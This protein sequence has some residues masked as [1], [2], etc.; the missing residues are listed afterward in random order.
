[1]DAGDFFRFLFRFID[2]SHNMERNVRFLR[3]QMAPHREKIIPFSLQEFSLLSHHLSQI[4]GGIQKRNGITG[5]IDTIYYEHLYIWA[6]KQWR[7]RDII[8]VV[9]ST[10]DKFVY[11]VQKDIFRVFM[12]GTEAGFIDSRG[13]FY[14]KSRQVIAYWNQISSA[15]T[16]QIDILG[17]KA[18]FVYNY[19]SED[20]TTPRLLQIFTELTEDEYTILMCLI[21]GKLVYDT[22]QKP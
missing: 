21:L 7:S 8:I 19:N 9:E 20:N 18:G 12:N 13:R 22:C 6:A 15:P 4:K 17:K 1:M 2:G 11:V 10:A 3:S 5:I 16:Q 14:N